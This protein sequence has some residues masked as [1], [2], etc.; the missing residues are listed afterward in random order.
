VQSIRRQ[1]EVEGT[2]DAEQMREQK[3]QQSTTSTP[4]A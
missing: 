3:L 4:P 1:R 2:L